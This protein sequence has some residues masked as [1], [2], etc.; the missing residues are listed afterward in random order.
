SELDFPMVCLINGYSASA[1]EVLSG[2]FQDHKRAL[3]VGDRSYGKGSVQTIEKF[4]GGGKIKVT[5]ATFF[6]PNGKNINRTR[7]SKE[8]DD[9]GVR[10]DINVKLSLKELED[11]REYQEATEVIQR[12]DKPNV[13]PLP[14]FKDKQLDAGLDY[15]RDQIKL[16]AKIPEKKPNP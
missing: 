5:I 13:K 10:P 12:K 4:E 15:L 2:C 7:E 8:S 9:W 16:A 1:S 6:R 14:S 11:L 3:I